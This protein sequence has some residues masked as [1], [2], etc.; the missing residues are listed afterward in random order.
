LP[1]DARVAREGEAVRILGAWVGNKTD[2]AMSWRP[3][4]ET[5]RRSLDRWNQRRP[6]LYGRRLIVNLELGSRTQFLTAAQGMPHTVEKELTDVAFQFMW[7]GQRHPP[8]ACDTLYAPVAEG[9]L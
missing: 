4:V 5:I 1:A 9:G 3:M 7:N 2:H 8:V 6:T